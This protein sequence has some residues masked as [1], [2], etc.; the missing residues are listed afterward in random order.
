MVQPQPSHNHSTGAPHP[1]DVDAILDA[2]MTKEYTA[3]MS[4]VT[5]KKMERGIALADLIRDLYERVRGLDMPVR[6]RVYVVVGMG[7]VEANL[8]R[9]C[10]EGVQTSGLVGVFKMGLE[11]A[12]K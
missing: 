8:A 10:G 12:G 1:A 2:L 7:E 4:Y 6:V 9:G 3:C 11:L 5:R